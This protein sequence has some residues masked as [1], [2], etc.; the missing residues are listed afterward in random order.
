MAREVTTWTPN[1]QPPIREASRISTDFHN[2]IIDAERRQLNSR[3]KKTQVSSTS[4]IVPEEPSKW[5]KY[6]LDTDPAEA[7]NFTT[8]ARLML[9]STFL[10]DLEAELLEGIKNGENGFKLGWP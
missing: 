9:D 5:E 10:A 1:F 7:T 8:P 2:E 3:A 6:A 4:T